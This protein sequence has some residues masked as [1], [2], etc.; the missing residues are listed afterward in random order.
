M[1]DPASQCQ[2]VQTHQA[3]WQVMTDLPYIPSSRDTNLC[4]PCGT[5]RL[6]VPICNARVNARVYMHAYTQVSMHTSQT[7][8]QNSMSI[9][10]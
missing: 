8:E 4:V 2:F 6:H 1:T 5:C 7:Q 9:C 3:R 10:R